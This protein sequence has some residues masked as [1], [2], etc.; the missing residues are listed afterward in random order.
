MNG[1][2]IRWRGQNEDPEADAANRLSKLKP[3]K[4]EK[5]DR[6]R[7]PDKDKVN[8]R[9]QSEAKRQTDNRQKE[10]QDYTHR[11]WADCAQVKIT[12]NR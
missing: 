6:S 3:T 9:M 7:E 4:T 1:T 2:D 5:R 10:R 11:S 12:E 8:T